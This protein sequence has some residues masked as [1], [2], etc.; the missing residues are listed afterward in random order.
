[1]ISIAVTLAALGVFGFVKA[2]FTS[3]PRLRSAL[4]SMLTGGLA[5]AAAFA[6][7]RLV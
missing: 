7:A 3:I 4:Q 5:A 1:M 2:Q 6:L